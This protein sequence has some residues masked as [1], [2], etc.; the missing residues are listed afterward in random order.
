[1]Q[2]TSLGASGGLEPQQGTSAFHLPPYTLIDAGTGAQ[3]LSIA[4]LTSLNSVLVT[5]AHLDHIASLPLLIDMQFDALAEQERSLNVYALP[6]VL[7]TLKRHIFNEHIW[8]DFTQLPSADSPVLQFVPITLWESFTL[9]GEANIPLQ[10]TPFPVSH[11]VPTCGY[12]INDGSKQVAICGDTGLNEN[13]ITAL[14]RLGPLN[15]LAIECAYSNHFDALAKISN[16]LTP[17]RLATLLDALDT[18]PEEL[19]ITHLKPKQRERIASELCQQLPS[20]L[21]WILPS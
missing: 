4:E 2:I 19:W 9:P 14:N 10:V 7:E 15:R 3:R 16:H 5:H 20:H 17:H 13:T 8:P 11:G 21:N 6:E 12:C 1:M 18:L